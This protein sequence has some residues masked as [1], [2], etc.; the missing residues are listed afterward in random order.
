[1]SLGS[2][3]GHRPLGICAVTLRVVE[4]VP[5]PNFSQAGGTH[6][7]RNGDNVCLEFTFAENGAV[8]LPT[9]G[10]IEI[11]FSHGAEVATYFE[12]GSGMRHTTIKWYNKDKVATKPA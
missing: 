7:S 9:I 3:F 1:M 6:W 12:V 2:G 11:T 10:G 5:T 4:S 8:G